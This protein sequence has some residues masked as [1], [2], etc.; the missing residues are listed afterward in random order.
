MEAQRFNWLSATEHD[1]K[2]LY[3][4]VLDY[5]KKTGLTWPEIFE[6]AFPDSDMLSTDYEAN[7]RKGKISRRRALMMSAWL[8]K[9][10]PEGAKKLSEKLLPHTI[11]AN[12]NGQISTWDQFLKRHQRHEGIEIHPWPGKSLN[13]V[14]FASPLPFA[15]RRIK[16]GE[17]FLFRITAPKGIAVA[18]W[19]QIGY[20]WYS[21]ALSPDQL[22][23]QTQQDNSWLPLDTN[24]KDP[25]PLNE[26]EQSGPHS[27][28][29]ITV[30]DITLLT[31]II[32]Q[33]S[34]G[35]IAPVT[36]DKWAEHFQSSEDIDWSVL[37][38]NV[39]FDA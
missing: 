1:R 10:S 36:L 23:I 12:D 2:Q 27:F 30:G 31:P 19:Q 33:V 25:L 7:F 38:C 18:A 22:I 11:K 8:E 4:V 16:L 32:R 28:V 14:K 34:Q 21:L 9:S 24:R 5:R 3:E 15:K 17:K 20:D 37:R 39:H 29:F 13:I 6:C 26:L 35:V